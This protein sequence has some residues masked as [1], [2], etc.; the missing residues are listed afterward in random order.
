MA[1]RI[2]L[3]DKGNMQS[4]EDYVKQRTSTEAN[5]VF[6][7]VT[8]VVDADGESAIPRQLSVSES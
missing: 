2:S 6:G 3:F 7:A 1:Q 4:F 8:S 5:D